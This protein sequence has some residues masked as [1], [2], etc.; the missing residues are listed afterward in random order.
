MASFDPKD[1]KP[2]DDLDKIAGD[3]GQIQ[4]PQDSPEDETSF[5]T[6]KFYAKDV[7]YLKDK[8]DSYSHYSDYTESF[9]RQDMEKEAGE[10]GYGKE[11]DQVFE[12][13]SKKDIEAMIDKKVSKKRFSWLPLVMAAILGALIGIG[14]LVHLAPKVL[15]DGLF[16]VNEIKNV[17]IN[18]EEGISVETAVYEKAKDSVVGITTVVSTMN[19]FFP[20]E[21]YSEG[22]GS[23]VVVSEDGYILTNSHVVSDGKAKTIKVILDNQDTYEGDL[24]WYEPEMDLAV[25]KVDAKGLK[26]IE[27]GDSDAIKVGEKSIAI[28]NPLGMDLQSTMTSGYI[29]G[30]DRSITMETGLVMDGLIQT[31]AAINGGNS[32][33]ALLNSKGQL[34]GINTAKASADNIGFA[35]PINTAKVIIDRVQNS[36]SFEPVTLGIRGVDLAYYEGIT[37]RVTGVETGIIVIETLGSSPAAMAGIKQGDI[38]THIDGIELMSMGVLRTQLLAYQP[39]DTAELDI[40]REKASEKIQVSFSGESI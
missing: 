8:L 38:I 4:G 26:P 34:I 30:L 11:K 19:Q 10:E 36:A 16:T 6:E 23:G 27:L 28:G 22:V 31:D 18:P 12:S 21:S 33:G 15:G 25:V 29:S 35:I 13:L 20:I 14:I 3:S 7:D 37:G 9:S 32:G 17:T 5:N 2:K 1:Q 40:I 24:I 39:G